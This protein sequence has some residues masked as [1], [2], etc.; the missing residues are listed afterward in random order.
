MSSVKQR[1]FCSEWRN[2]VQPHSFYYSDHIKKAVRDV[3]T[4]ARE[5]TAREAKAF[6]SMRRR[7]HDEEDEEE[8]E[9]EV[10]EIRE[11]GGD[12]SYY[13]DDELKMKR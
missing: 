13:Y 9:E 11:D 12:V 8:E 4:N 10:E 3:Q 5:I 2:S 1:P 7:E 6:L